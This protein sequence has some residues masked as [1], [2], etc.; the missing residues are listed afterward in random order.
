MIDFRPKFISFDCYGTL[1]H[2]QMSAVT[3]GLYA[4]R[5]SE[6]RMEDF[7]DD[8]EAYRIDEVLGAYQPYPEVITNAL[9]R[10]TA[11]WDLPYR[12]SDAEAIVAAVPTWGPHPDVPEALAKLAEAFPLVILSNAADDQIGGNVARLGAPFHAVLT[13]QQARAYKPRLAAFEYMF[14]QLGCAPGDLLHVSS[15]LRYDLIPAHDLRITNKVY[16]N[17]GYEP[18]TPYYGYTEI[19]AL[20]ELPALLGL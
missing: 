13:A 14:A 7:L 17:R 5:I 2:F 11:L 9:R 3:R 16:L 19:T 10:A 6:E 1:T 8:F 20:T 4:D 15:S 18:S 12:D